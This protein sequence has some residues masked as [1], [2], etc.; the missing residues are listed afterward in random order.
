MS[1][2]VM[3]YPSSIRRLINEAAE[4]LEEHADCGKLVIDL[5]MNTGGWSTVIWALQDT[6]RQLKPECTYVLTGGRTMSMAINAIACFRGG[7][8]AITVGE[9]T[10]QFSSFFAYS[11]DAENE[12]RFTFPHSQLE[13][14]VSNLWNDS[15]TDL[16]LFDIDYAFKERYDET[17]RLYEWENT[18]LP[19]VYV[20]Q[21]I[22]DIR[23]GRESVMEWVLAQ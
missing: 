16:P 22:E 10:G 9:P 20:Y 11:G 18:I 23:Q 15:A 13:V 8:D 14:E 7:L 1:F 3:D 5:R 4:L 12:R 21:D 19:D 6:V 2:A 17:G